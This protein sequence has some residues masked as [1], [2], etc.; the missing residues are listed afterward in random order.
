[1]LLGFVQVSLMFVWGSLAFGLELWTPRHLTG[2][3][4]LTAVTA[5]AAAGFG[6]VLAAACRTRAQLN[7][8]SSVIILVMSAV[9]G[10]MF[11]R[12]LMPETLRELGLVT[13]NAWALDGYQKIFWYEAPLAGL[14]PQ[15]RA[16]W[17]RGG[18]EP[19]SPRWIFESLA[20]LEIPETQSAI[21]R[22]G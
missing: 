9:G 4:V 15:R 2:F 3:L 8:V 20:S 17:R 1:M 21:L 18:N 7:G 19:E 10:S 13:F 12:F 6:L 22:V 14:A 5:A 16:C 11:P